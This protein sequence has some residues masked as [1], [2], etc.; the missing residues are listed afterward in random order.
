MVKKELTLLDDEFE[1]YTAKVKYPTNI[2]GH[3]KNQVTDKVQ[4]VKNA[5]FEDGMTDEELMSQIDN[6]GEL[7]GEAQ[8]IIMSFALKHMRKVESDELVSKD[9]LSESAYQ[10]V[11]EQYS[12]SIQGV[13]VGKN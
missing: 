6:V 5:H 3:V 12:D 9:E 2:P 7:M 11:L 4:L 13:K 10:T 8:E 1:E